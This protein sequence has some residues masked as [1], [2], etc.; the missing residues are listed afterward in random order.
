[1]NTPDINE[2]LAHIRS[3][4]SL[5]RELEKKAAAKLEKA[6]PLLGKVLEAKS[7]QSRKVAAIARSVWN[8]ET[9]VNL[10][11]TLAGL[12]ADV[13]QGV[14]ALIAARAHM[15]GNADNLIRPLATKA[16]LYAS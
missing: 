13:A 8:D 15:G 10:C 16:Q 11:D 7:G 5:A 1:M 9:A 3:R 14:I 2:A 6:L 12:D 4:V